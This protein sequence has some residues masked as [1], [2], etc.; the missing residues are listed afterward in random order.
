MSTAFSVDQPIYGPEYR[1]IN[2]GTPTQ[3]NT[4]L[5]KRVTSYRVTTNTPN[6]ARYKKVNYPGSAELP[7]HYFSFYREI[8]IGGSGDVREHDFYNPS[9]YIVE[10]GYHSNS[11][12]GM[13]GGVVLEPTT[14]MLNKLQ[15]RVNAKLLEK[16][17]DQSANFAQIFAERKMT[18]DLIGD[19][20]IK[21]ASSFNALK[22]GNFRQAARNLGV[23]ASRRKTVAFN[24]A[25]GRNRN[26]AISNG[27]LQLQYGW[28]PLL[29]D[30]YG[31]AEFLA[32]KQ[33]HEIHSVVRSR[34]PLKLEEDLF[35]P[36]S[37]NYWDVLYIRKSTFDYSGLIRFAT[38]G[39]E[40]A[41]AKEAGLTNPLSVAWELTPYSFVVDWF[42]PVGNYLNSLDATLGLTFQSGAY[43]TFLRGSSSIT[44]MADNRRGANRYYSNSV[45]NCR[46]RA[47]REKLLCVR[48]PF[49]TFPGPEL[50][51]FKNPFSFEHALNGIAL[52]FQSFKR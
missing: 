35:Y 1:S 11:F 38:T 29:Q 51:S 21:L 25:Y 17:K 40:L 33:C 39:A 3:I 12:G 16:L 6:F 47:S 52:L 28:R 9:Q 18:A 31:S 45:F 50:P 37:P 32:K 34:I 10:S 7:I 30:I 14:D 13:D 43:T 48:T 46:V 19:T 41:S 15:S 22:K 4:G 8:V 2:G 24:R 5:A 20:A 44:L 49:S 27:W 36:A 23:G 26:N 42:L